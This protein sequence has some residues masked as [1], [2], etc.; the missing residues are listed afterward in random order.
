MA[1]IIHD[2]NI[3]HRNETVKMSEQTLKAVQENKKIRNKLG[4]GNAHIQ[5]CNKIPEIFIGGLVYQ[6]ERLIVE[7][8]EPHSISKINP[9]IFLV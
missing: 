8:E 7:E 4:G 3:N 6:R 1:F 9:K 5:W 2:E